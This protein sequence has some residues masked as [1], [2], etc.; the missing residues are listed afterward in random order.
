MK[1]PSGSAD[2]KDTMLATDGFSNLIDL[3]ERLCQARVLV[4]GD[5]M[6]DQFVRG[7]VERV[8][9]EA[10][11]PILAI[12]DEISM[13]GGA[14]NVVRNLATLGATV[15]FAGVVGDDPAGETIRDLL[16]SYANVQSRLTVEPGR[17]TSVKTRFVA[18]PAHLLRTDRET[19]APVSLESRQALLAHLRE[20]IPQ[21]SAVMVSD[22]GKGTL[23]PDLLHSLMDIA[24]AHQVQVVV[25]PKGTDYSRYRGASIITPNRTELAAAAGV[26]LVDESSYEVAARK[27]LATCNAD[28]VLVTRSEEGLSIYAAAG[29]NHHI[30]ATGQEVFDVSGAGDTVAAI[31]SAG[32][33]IGAPLPACACVANVGA[34]IVVRKVGTAVVHP[35]ELR[36]GVVQHLVAEPSP[37]ALSLERIVE[38]VRLWRSMGLSIGFTNGCFD[39]LHQGHAT[40][41]AKARRECDRL[42][43]GLNSDA[44]IGRLKGPLRPVQNEEARSRLLASLT[45]VDAVVL[46]HEDT[47]LEVIRA[48]WP[49]VLFKGADYALKDVVGADIVQAHGGRVMLIDLEPD[50]STTDIIHRILKTNKPVSDA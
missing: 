5:I 44:S 40:M 30:R 24:A 42:I 43:V 32:L 50:C 9:P 20:A 11:I 12:I 38:C 14:G 37:Q 28:A 49:D 15:V 18:G 45:A 27:I 31:L 46:F 21:V 17:R 33:A 6:L 48:I 22:Y 36:Q 8:S 41:L 29:G 2:W 47:P 3:C 13:L 26:Q 39:L 19:L 4:V 10:P 16:G 7:K 34:G 23:T 25:D 1:L 35:E